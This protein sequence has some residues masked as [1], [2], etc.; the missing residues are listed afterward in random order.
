MNPKKQIFRIILSSLTLLCVIACRQAFAQQ[1]NIAQRKML[2]DNGWRFYRGDAKD[3]E[4]P[5]FNDALWRI[6][7]LPHDWSIEPLKDQIP[8]ETIGPFSKRSPGGAATGQTIGGA[9]WYRKS[10]VI[11]Q[12]DAK[13]ARVV[14]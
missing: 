8:G 5:S 3:A 2:F 11:D 13:K 9:G 14:F 7:T 12:K 1:G 4:Q 6:V 10:F